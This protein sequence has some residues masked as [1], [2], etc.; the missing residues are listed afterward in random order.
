M[1]AIEF[2]GQTTIIA[3]DQPQY[4]PLP[5]RVSQDRQRIVTSCWVF[6]WKERL[7][8]LLGY[9][10]FWSQITFGDPLQPVMS[11]ISKEVPN[12]QGE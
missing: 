2:E 9:K 8:I 12:A 10:L 1:K 3:K 6:S 5:A 7:K 11:K 4:I